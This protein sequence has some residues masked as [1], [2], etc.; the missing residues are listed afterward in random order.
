[1]LRRRSDTASST[2]SS[3]ALADDS[4]TVSEGAAPK[5]KA[6]P[7]RREAEQARKAALKPSA[8]TKEGKR[9]ERQRAQ[10]ERAENRE[11]MMA[12]D[13][14]ALPARD[15]GPVKLFVRNYVDSRRT[16]GEFFLPAA[17]IIFIA[18]L[19]PNPQIKGFV[20]LL[21]MVV[22]VIAAVDTALLIWRMQRALAVKWPSKAERRGVTFYAIMRNLQIRRLR[23][24]PPQFR[25]GGRPVEPKQPKRK[26]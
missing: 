16:V 6:T 13:P 4:P 24:P 10:S 15:Q 21:W 8:T 11:A 26:A 18:T 20:S 12:G 2:A 14:R 9:A 1:M 3:T 23:I 7:K 17:F 5:G 25:S 22:M 19:S